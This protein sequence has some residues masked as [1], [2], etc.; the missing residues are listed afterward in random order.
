MN[1][2]SSPADPGVEC[3]GQTAEETPAMAGTLCGEGGGGEN[4]CKFINEFFRRFSS[5][6][7]GHTF[8]LKRLQLGT[9][10][11]THRDVGETW[12]MRVPVKY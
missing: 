1:P 4:L 10:H 5:S 3:G 2:L 9:K 6:I 11:K 12:F 8:S 7:F